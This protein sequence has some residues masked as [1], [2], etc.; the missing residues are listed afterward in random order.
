MISNPP[1]KGRTAF[2]YRKLDEQN[3]IWF[4]GLRQSGVLPEK[5][6]VPKK[7]LPGTCT[8]SALRPSTTVLLVLTVA[9]AP[10]A[11]AWSR[12]STVACT[13]EPISVLLLPVGLNEPAYE[14]K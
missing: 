13:F 6:S 7:S 1:R 9:S 4:E 10:M 3:E 11:V 12:L 8:A 14:P 2:L 5:P